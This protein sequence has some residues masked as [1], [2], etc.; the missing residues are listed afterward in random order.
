MRSKGI[1][2]IRY[3]TAV[4]GPTKMNGK[5]AFK[6]RVAANSNSVIATAIAA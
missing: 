2:F 5:N 3:G 1:I 6:T 4:I